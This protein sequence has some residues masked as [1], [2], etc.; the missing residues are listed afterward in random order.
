MS[1]QKQSIKIGKT[2]YGNKTLGSLV[3]RSFKEVVKIIPPPDISKFF[4]M[5]DELFFS[6]PLEGEKSHNTLIESS[7]DYFTDYKDPKD[8][9]IDELNDT[10]IELEERI[11]QLENPDEH[12]FYKN[13]TVI[14]RGGGGNYYYMELGKRRRITGG[15]PGEAW[16]ALKASMGFKETDNDFETKAV[17]K[18][19]RN[20]VDQIPEGPYL[21]I[22]DIAGGKPKSIKS[23]TLK[24]D[25]SDR[26]ANPDLYDSIEDYQK[27]LEKEIN[28]AWDLEREMES[29]Y[30]K[31]RSVRNFGETESEREEGRKMYKQAGPEL[32]KVRIKLSKFKRIYEMIESGQNVTLTGVDKLYEELFEGDMTDDYLV[33]QREINSFKGWEK[34]NFGDK[35][36]GVNKE[37]GEY[38]NFGE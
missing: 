2:V 20:I 1:Y 36:K 11:D 19:A 23:I 32:K 6:I 25:P 30:Y 14:S 9:E 31:W 3:D 24:L 18:V 17:I 7:R 8:D 15:S 33:T 13:G 4:K 5:Y 21:D 38:Y 35:R 10:I 26:K 16:A 37:T 27:A 29:Q 28:E 34:G 22:E 12:A